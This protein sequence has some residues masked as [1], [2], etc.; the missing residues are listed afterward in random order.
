MEIA[1]DALGAEAAGRSGPLS[2]RQLIGLGAVGVAAVGA[3]VTLGLRSADRT[4]RGHQVTTP[5]DRRTAA[6]RP[7]RFWEFAVGGPVYT[8]LAGNAGVVYVNCRKGLY[9]LQAADGSVLWRSKHAQQYPAP[10]VAAADVVYLVADTNTRLFALNGSDGSTRWALGDSRTL[11]QSPVVDGNHVYVE[12]DFPPFG[13]GPGE[14]VALDAHTGEKIW[15]LPA[16]SS[17]NSAGGPSIA[18]GATLY[19]LS[20]SVLRALSAADGSGQWSCVTPS[21]SL[22]GGPVIADSRVYVCC[23]V[24]NGNN[25][26]YVLAL[27]A[28]DGNELW[29]ATVPGGPVS[30]QVAGDILYASGETG[31]VCALKTSDGTPLWTTAVDGL[32]KDFLVAERTVFVFGTP[33][34]SSGG[35]VN[36]GGVMGA[37]TVLALDASDGATRWQITVD[38]SQPNAPPAVAGDLLLFGIYEGHFYAVDRATGTTQWTS[39]IKLVSGPVLAGDI[40]VAVGADNI[41][42]SGAVSAAGKVFAARF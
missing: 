25:E 31:S 1:D 27:D 10:L 16:G 9:A 17:V 12:L 19:T 4:S 7:E 5:A 26:S 6:A 21:G 41:S 3:G 35:L 15:S 18:V 20:D 36:A 40:V 24:A 23:G 22:N 32:N 29:T 14:V 39:P 33:P 8:T 2:R 38:G 30:L 28:N 34:A 37:T 42:P 13:I 11:V